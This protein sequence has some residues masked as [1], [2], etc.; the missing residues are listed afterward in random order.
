M[1]TQTATSPSGRAGVSGAVQQPGLHRRFSRGGFTLV[2]ILIVVIILGILAAIAIPQFSNASHV[3]RENTLKDELRYLREQ[4]VVYQA[5][6]Q[7][8]A[9]GTQNG[10]LGGSPASLFV[11]QMTQYTDMYGNTSPTQTGAFVYGPYLSKMPPN[12]LT[13]DATIQIITGG[14]TTPVPDNSTAWIYNPTTGAI[15]VNSTSTGSDGT[16]YVMY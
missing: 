8:G 4:I 13:G 16:P 1:R 14:S 6:H 7:D 10:A 11:Q 15:V 12:P 9:P 3:T 2:E 5:Q